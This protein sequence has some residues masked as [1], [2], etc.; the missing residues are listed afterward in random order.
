MVKK[1]SLVLFFLLTTQ[2][3][4][5]NP[6]TSLL[7]G[8]VQ[9]AVLKAYANEAITVDATAG[10]VAF[11]SSLVNPTCTS[12]PI[13]TLRAQRVDCVS[14]ANS[15]AQFRVTI[16][17]TA[18]TTTVGQLITSGQSFTVYGYS[19]ILAFRAIRTAATS[20]SMYCVFSR[21]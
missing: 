11:T 12:C 21:L 13:N 14:E 18:P 15:G 9:I 8:N 10:G 5:Q 1:I 6:G 20:T 16:T 17:G 7:T 3:H 19:N 2:V 4:A